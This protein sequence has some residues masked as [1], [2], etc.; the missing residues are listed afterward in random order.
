M[1]FSKA[2]LQQANKSSRDTDYDFDVMD[3]LLS[4][5]ETPAQTPSTSPLLHGRKPPTQII[6]KENAWH[7]QAAYL[8]AQGLTQKQVAEAVGKSRASVQML[9]KQPWFQQEIVNI[10]HNERIE[11][12]AFKLLQ[13]ASAAAAMTIINIAAGGD[14]I[15][16][17]T[18]L[19][20]SE[21]ILA[22]TLG[23]IGREKVQPTNGSAEG[24]DEIDNLSEQIKTIEQNLTIL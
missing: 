11:D 8:I 23:P 15:S 9:F 20:A 13:N 2:D 18:Q 5:R 19:K 10:I 21:A 22:R 4:P 14:N 3:G 7:R 1:S 12:G 16:S 17:A 24:L 6:Q